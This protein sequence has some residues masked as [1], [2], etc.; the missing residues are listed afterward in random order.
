M[1]GKWEHTGAACAAPVGRG[2]RGRCTVCPHQASLV[3]WGSSWLILAPL[4]Q[5]VRHLRTQLLVPG[6]EAAEGWSV[7]KLPQPLQSSK[8]SLQ[9]GSL[10]EQGGVACGTGWRGCLNI[11][12]VGW[13]GLERSLKLIQSNSLPLSTRLYCSNP[14]QPGL[15]ISWDRPCWEISILEVSVVTVNVCQQQKPCQGTL[16]LSCNTDLDVPVHSLLS[17]PVFLGKQ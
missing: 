16:A 15:N 7:L 3:T 10:A 13:F 5:P 12:G 6:V 4:E 1:D 8:S 14:V 11:H 2:K 17:L 9:A